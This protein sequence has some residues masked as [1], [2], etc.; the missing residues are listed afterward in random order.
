[1][2]TSKNT[3]IIEAK[4]KGFNKAK[5]NIKGV[6][7]SLKGMAK[8]ALAAG[9]ALYGAKKLLDGMK[10][11]INLAAEQELAEKKLEAALCG[12]SKELKEY[13]RELKSPIGF[14]IDVLVIDRFFSSFFL[15][16]K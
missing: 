8:A 3:Q 15:N 4:T 6:D 13:A 10:A 12:V 14:S 16:V 9:A 11:A 2:T 7:S 1:M 5:K